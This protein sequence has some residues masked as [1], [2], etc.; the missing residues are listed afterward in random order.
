M[1]CVQETSTSSSLV[2]LD[3]F[4]SLNKA[5]QEYDEKRETVIQES[6][7]ALSYG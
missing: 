2:D 3:A 1:G 7:G 5:M 6:R 4:A